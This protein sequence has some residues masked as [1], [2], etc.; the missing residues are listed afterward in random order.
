MT[1]LVL[2][3]DKCRQ[4]IFMLFEGSV[5]PTRAKKHIIIIYFDTG[6]Q[7]PF[8]YFFVMARSNNCNF[9]SRYN[10]QSKACCGIIK[11]G[12]TRDTISE[13]NLVFLFFPR[14]L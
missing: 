14:Y 8:V 9:L 10:S 2:A 6:S 5:S 11:A 12:E 1:F 3:L 4:G 13:T 7:I